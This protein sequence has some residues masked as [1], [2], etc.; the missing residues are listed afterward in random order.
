MKPTPAVELRDARV[1]LGGTAVLRG[2]NATFE[3][4]TLVGVLGPNGAGK[5]TLLRA[6]AG[7]VPLDGG[8]ARLHGKRLRGR[9]R[10]E[11][12]RQVNL[13]PQNVSL[14]FAFRVREIVAMGRHAH[15]GRFEGWT[16]HDHEAVDWAMDATDVTALAERFVTEL[17]GGERQRVLIARSLATEAPVLLLDEP[18]ASVDSRHALEIMDLLEHIADEGKTVVTA[19]HDLNL[20]RRACGQ[21]LLLCE[22]RVVAAGEAA[23]ALCPGHIEHVF[24][25]RAE[26][27][28]GDRGLW[29]SLPPTDGA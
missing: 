3:P 12:A 14:S 15:R 29:F 17:S 7:L 18:T 4:A 13:L 21:V 1:R 24:G 11:I 26:P 8:E 22:G 27:L 19:L 6:A 23:E 9:S 5:S 2:V 25:V 20:A 10:R 28:P 16:A